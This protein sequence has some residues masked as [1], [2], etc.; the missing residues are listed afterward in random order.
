MASLSGLI[1]TSTDASSSTVF[2][3]G[4]EKKANNVPKFS[5]Q[6]MILVLNMLDILSSENKKYP[7]T[8]F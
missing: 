4:E 8:K 5:P 1:I 7:P 6:N 2:N 3:C